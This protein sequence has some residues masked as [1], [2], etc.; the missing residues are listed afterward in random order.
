MNEHPKKTITFIEPVYPTFKLYTDRIE[1]FKTN[2]WP[3]GLSQRP[4]M[5]AEAGF[6]Y[7]G[8]GDQ[9]ICYHCGGCV[10]QWMKSDDPWIEHMKFFPSCNYI[11]IIQPKHLYDH[12]IK[13]DR[14]L[15]NNQSQSINKKL[16]HDSHDIRMTHNESSLLNKCFRF[17]A[18]ETRGTKTSGVHESFND[19]YDERTCKVFMLIESNIV[20]TPCGHFIVC[21]FCA[22]TLSE[23]PLCRSKIT[24]LIKVYF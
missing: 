8:R 14:S 9:V 11:S 3:I 5:L 22:A 4:H 1:T 17:F 2:H 23:C 15:I 16:N 19:S 13:E 20:L 18:K 12:S 24:E 6:F 10:N 21:G 7:T